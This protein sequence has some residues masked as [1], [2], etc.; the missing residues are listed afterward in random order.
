MIESI[1][2]WI[3]L[4]RAVAF[5]ALILSIV[6]TCFSWKRGRLLHEQEKRKTLQLDATLMHCFYNSDEATGDR[7]YEFQLMVRNPSDG[8]NAISEADLKI[9]YIT[10]ERIAM[11]AKSEQ[12]KPIL[13]VS[14]MVRP[15]FSKFLNLSQLGTQ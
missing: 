9:S 13:P 10:K 1:I 8:N 14:F 3:D 11:T 15:I 5:S 4:T 12:M 7:F 2:S 6:N